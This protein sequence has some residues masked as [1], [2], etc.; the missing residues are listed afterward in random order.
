M[1]KILKLISKLIGWYFMF[2]ATM[3]L[4][5][6]LMYAEER[7]LIS[8]SIVILLPLGILFRALSLSMK[9]KK[10]RIIKSLDNFFILLLLRGL[11]LISSHLLLPHPYVMVITHLL[12]VGI[13]FLIIGG[14]ALFTIGKIKLDGEFDDQNGTVK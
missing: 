6:G 9:A 11:T 14:I 8:F 1:K 2:L 7:G 10:T 4:S 12:I 5:E 13:S 3:G